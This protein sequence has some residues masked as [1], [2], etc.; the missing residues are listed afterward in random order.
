VTPTSAKNVPAPRKNCDFCGVEERESKF[1]FQ[2]TRSTLHK[3]KVQ[4]YVQVEK[5]CN[6]FAK[7]NVMAPSA[8]LSGCISLTSGQ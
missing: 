7:E 3:T 4:L 5:E 8:L 1:K 2:V 6:P